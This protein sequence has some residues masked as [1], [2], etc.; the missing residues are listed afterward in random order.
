[1]SADFAPPDNSPKQISVG[2]GRSTIV[3]LSI[4]LAAGCSQAPRQTNESTNIPATTTNSR[5]ASLTQPADPIMPAGSI[6]IIGLELAEAL[7]IYAALAGAQLDTSSLGTTLPPVVIQF[8]NTNAVTRSE[9]VRLF[10]RALYEQ[11]GLV[12]THP[13]KTHVVFEHRP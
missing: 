7:K 5:T 12:A 10:D 13:D 4:L 8:T 6:N 1:M 2:A 9:A 11:A 3:V